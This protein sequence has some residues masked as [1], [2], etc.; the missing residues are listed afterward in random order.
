[1]VHD[2]AEYLGDCDDLAILRDTVFE[3]PGVYGNDQVTEYL[4]GLIDQRCA[5]LQAG[6]W[7]VGERIY[8]ET[9]G[10]P[11]GHS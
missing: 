11:S 8:V 2:L 10:P 7:S 4:I 9:P 5:E 6:A 3:E 1:M